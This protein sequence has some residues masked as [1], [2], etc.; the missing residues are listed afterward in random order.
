M[1]KSL[2]TICTLLLLAMVGNTYALKTTFMFNKKN[3][4]AN[5][6][7][8]Q[9]KGDAV[10]AQTSQIPEYCY[11][12]DVVWTS[13][14]GNITITG[15]NY[16]Y[17]FY[18]KKYTLSLCGPSGGLKDGTTGYVT[19]KAPEGYLITNLTIGG[20]TIS[21][22]I[23]QSGTGTQGGGTS[24]SVVKTWEGFSQDV[25]I[26][27]NAKS[28]SYVAID[29]IAVTYGKAIDVKVT[30]AGYGTLYYS[31]T[32][33]M[34]P[35]GVTA[36]TYTDVKSGYMVEGTKYGE[37]KVIPAGEAVVIKANEG[38]YQFVEMETETEKSDANIL[39][40]TD[41]DAL[42]VGPKE[43]VE[44][45]FYKLS[46]DAN[47]TAGTV[48]FYWGGNGGDAFT[49]KAHKAYLPIP[50]SQAMSAPRFLF[51]MEDETVTGISNAKQQ[52]ASDAVYTLSGVRM[53]NTQ[54]LPAGIYVKNGKKYLVK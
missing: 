24:T 18:N 37:R 49:N 28:N 34:V 25:T 35:T 43:D 9:Y 52:T 29:S 20:T 39:M 53:S 50:R 19:L 27:W 5:T 54:A 23:E 13:D 6:Y 4:V 11:T 22:N 41:E 46:L 30:A 17:R 26:Q 16:F 33:I 1:K 42:T 36:L 8:A 21:M 14:D 3:G 2:R 47:N 7:G 40:G 32:G 45:K 48:G 15:Y 31:T 44:Y 10:K 38:T 51:E 12:T